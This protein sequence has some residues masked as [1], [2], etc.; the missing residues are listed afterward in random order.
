[1]NVYL[2]IRFILIDY[3]LWQ[4]TH[5]PTCSL[6]RPP[7]T[8]WKRTR[9]PERAIGCPRGFPDCS[10]GAPFPPSRA[11][12]IDVIRRRRRRWNVIQGRHAGASD[13]PPFLRPCSPRLPLRRGLRAARLAGASAAP[14]RAPCPDRAAGRTWPWWRRPAPPGS[15]PRWLGG[16]APS[17]LGEFSWWAPSG[18]AESGQGARCCSS[19]S[20]L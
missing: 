17:L 20:R 14:L 18:I 13:L 19:S 11:Q 5:S 1:M 4:P 6:S 8:F 3:L 12:N 9:K 16:A 10:A 15:S 2:F 7:S